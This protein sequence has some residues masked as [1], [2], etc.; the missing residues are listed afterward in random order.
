MFVMCDGEPWNSGDD[1]VVNRQN[2]LTVNVNE[3]NLGKKFKKLKQ[4]KKNK[5]IFNFVEITVSL[6]Q[7]Y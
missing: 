4:Y 2:H 6:N 5:Q 3:C 7:I 1:V